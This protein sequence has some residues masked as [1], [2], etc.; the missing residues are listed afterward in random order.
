VAL[1]NVG[2]D[3]RFAAITIK[4]FTPGTYTLVAV[5]IDARGYG[6]NSLPFSLTVLA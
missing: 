6:F 3:G 1:A 5:A 4:P 2:A